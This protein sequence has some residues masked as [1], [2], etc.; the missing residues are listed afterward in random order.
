MRYSAAKYLAR[1]SSLLPLD[2]R[3]QVVSATIGLFAGTADEPVVETPFGTIVDPGGS[4]HAG[5]MG[6][7]GSEPIRGE[8]RWHGICLALAEMARRGLIRE[9][10]VSK[11]IRWVL[12]VRRTSHYVVLFVAHQVGFDLRSATRVTLCRLECPGCSGLSALVAV[13][14]VLAR[15]S[16]SICDPDR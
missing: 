3:D 11:T 4:E 2:F 6:F 14:L 5:S 8:A 10:S 9:D 1:L 7:G 13:S 12:K 15:N 16:G